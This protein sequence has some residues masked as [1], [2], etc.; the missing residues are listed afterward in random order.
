[1][2]LF[3]ATLFGAAAIVTLLG[4]LLPH[5]RQID[6]AG[7]GVVTAAAA[8]IAIVLLN[9]GDRAPR[10]FY[11]LVVALGTALVSL[12]I[13]SNSERHGGAAGGDEM[14]YLWV[15]LY[16]AY[17]MS[18]LATAA[19]V[20][21]VAVSYGLVLVVVDPGDVATSRWLSTVG[22]VVGSAVVVR[23]L[24]ERIECLVAS[25]GAAAHTD[26][27]PGLATRLSFEDAYLRESARAARHGTPFALLLA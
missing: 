5:Q 8:A 10:W 16:A 2:A 23:L 22:L 6:A 12:A 4:L 13:V 7:L 25:L 21:L 15:V 19:Q 18:R 24:S 1:M 17:F 20:A 3:G 27:L 11:M 14:Y 26:P 9:W